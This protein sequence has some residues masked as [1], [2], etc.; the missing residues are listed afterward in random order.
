MQIC[1]GNVVNNML[2]VFSGG[3]FRSRGRGGFGNRSGSNNVPVG[4][5]RPW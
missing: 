2:I 5:K 1:C 3:N 4:Y